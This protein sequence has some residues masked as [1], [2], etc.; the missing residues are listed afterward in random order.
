MSMK[1][2]AFDAIAVVAAR[3]AP[4]GLAAPAVALFATSAMAQNLLSNPDFEAGNTG[5]SS[6][7]VFVAS[8]GDTSADCDEN[9]LF[10]PF[11]YTVGVDPNDFH[12]AW[13][14]YGDH[15]TG[16][17]KMMIV[18]A[19]SASGEQCFDGNEDKDVVWSQTVTVSP[20]RTYEFGYW[21]ALAV[22]S[23]APLLQVSIN[24]SPIGTYDA[25]AITSTGTWTEVTHEWESETATSAVITIVDLD[26]HFSGDDYTLDDLSFVSTEIEVD[27]NVHPGSYPNPLNLLSGGS[28]PVAIFGSPTFDVT[29]IDPSTLTLGSAGLKVAGK[30]GK[31]MCSVSDIG[32][33]VP[34]DPTATPF[35][36][37]GDPDGYDD[38]VCHFVT[39]EI[40]PMA[41]GDQTVV[42][43]MGYL[44][45]G[46][47]FAGTDVVKVVKEE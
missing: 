28:T 6:E 29:E 45:D 25:S 12:T 34:G 26:P 1:V 27:I 5:F 42:E 9:S 44:M 30:S 18:N 41:D 24:G 22:L 35:D 23:N 20:N 21:I 15:T 4:L 46:T 32:E 7:Y 11:T 3:G 13:V 14:S 39:S 47:P 36:N 37:L 16:S 40:T 10:D 33:Y 19:A 17:G 2:K 38:L 43:V 8:N 31:D